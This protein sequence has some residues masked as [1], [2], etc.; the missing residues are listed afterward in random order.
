MQ[1]FA[2]TCAQNLFPCFNE[3]KNNSQK[4][5]NKVIG[6]SIGSATVIYEIMAL[7]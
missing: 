5:M 1:V 6:T 2:Y 4:R 3:L 7:A